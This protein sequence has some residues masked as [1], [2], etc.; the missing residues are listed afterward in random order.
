MPALFTARG[1]GR[2]VFPPLG[3]SGCTNCTY[4][5]FLMRSFA[6]AE[7]ILKALFL[8]LEK[9]PSQPRAEAAFSV[10]VSRFINFCFNSWCSQF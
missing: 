5:I 9:G 4:P 7:G 10:V 8:D 6:K 3:F 1:R 2:I